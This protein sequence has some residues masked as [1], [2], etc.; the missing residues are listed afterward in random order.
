MFSVAERAGLVGYDTQRN[1]PEKETIRHE[2]LAERPW[3][4]WLKAQSYGSLRV[5]L[6]HPQP[7]LA[8]GALYFVRV[9]LLTT[10]GDPP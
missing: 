5:G 10:V 8:L 3:P 1:A 6:L 4:F 7:I 9:V 2:V